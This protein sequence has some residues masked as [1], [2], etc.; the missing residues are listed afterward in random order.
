MGGG[1]TLKDWQVLLV[2]MSA[3]ADLPT[4]AE[5]RIIRRSDPRVRL[6]VPAKVQFLSGLKS[7]RLDNL[8]QRGARIMLAEKAP[9]VGASGLLKV[10]RI[11]AFGE[12]IWSRGTACGLRF[13][14]KL[15]LKEVVN[16]RHFGD[17]LVEIE[18][19]GRRTMVR[20]FVQGRRGA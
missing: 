13:D 4:D 5:F 8:S 6:G 9:A 10:C 16:V 18:A 19:A 12:V 7:C 2:R 20:N 17:Q 11:E 14:D 1:R 3:P 15:P